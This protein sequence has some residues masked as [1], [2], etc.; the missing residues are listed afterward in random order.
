VLTTIAV[1]FVF[2]T[3][4]VIHELGHWFGLND[5]YTGNF[6]ENTM[7]G[8]G[9]KGETKKISPENGDFLG[10]NLIY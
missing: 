10:L 3:V 2:T 9:S 7:Y 1:L 4:V 8:Y 6:V 5:H